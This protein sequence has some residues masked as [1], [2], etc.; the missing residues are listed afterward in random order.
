MGSEGLLGAG[1]WSFFGLGAECSF[2]LEGLGSTVFLG[3]CCFG[4]EVGFVTESLVFLGS[5]FFGS[6]CFL[7]T[8]SLGLALSGADSFGAESCL[9]PETGFGSASFFGTGIAGTECFFGWGSEPGSGRIDAEV[10]SVPSH[11]EALTLA[12]LPGPKAGRQKI[13]N[14]MHLGPRVK[15]LPQHRPTKEGWKGEWGRFEYSRPVALLG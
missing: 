15:V 10:D 5:G 14:G 11:L 8:G 9:G 2:E 4:S 12:S 3:S 7:G 13:A 1:L 6:D